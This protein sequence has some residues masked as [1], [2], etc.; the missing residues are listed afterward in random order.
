MDFRHRRV[1]AGLRIVENH[2]QC[3]LQDGLSPVDGRTA[4]HAEQIAKLQN[5]WE[6]ETMNVVDCRLQHNLVE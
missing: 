5:E 2:D 3:F 4:L 6:Q 1:N